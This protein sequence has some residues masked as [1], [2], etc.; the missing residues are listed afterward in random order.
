MK[1][2]MKVEDLRTALSSLSSIIPKKHANKCITNTLVRADSNKVEFTGYNGLIQKTVTAKC[3]TTEAME[4]LFDY[5]RVNNLSKMLPDGKNVTFTLKDKKLTVS[6][7][8]SRS[9]LMTMPTDTYPSMSIGDTISVNHDPDEISKGIDAVF[10]ASDRDNAKREINGVALISTGK[11]LDIVATNGARLAAYRI[12]TES[13]SVFSMIVPYSAVSIVSKSLVD[14]TTVCTDGNSII[15]AGDNFSLVCNLVN[16]KYVPYERAIPNDSTI[17]TKLTFSKENMVNTLNRIIA[18]ADNSISTTCIIESEAESNDATLHGKNSSLSQDEITE[19]IPMT[20]E[21]PN[22]VSIGFN[23]RFIMDAISKI[24]KETIV[25]TIHSG[26]ISP[27][28]LA[29]GYFVAVITKKII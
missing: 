7:G 12:P 26:G 21:S 2:T 6:C 10:H 19:S 20:N 23:P 8:K 27:M 4:V 15:I 9:T 28:V 17:E 18:I 25:C 29:D 11:S 14:A 22:S 3:D 13:E 24:D 16:M 1:F 5:S